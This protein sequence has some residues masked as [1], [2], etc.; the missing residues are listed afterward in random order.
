MREGDV[1]AQAIDWSDT[2][3]VVCN[4]KI[5]GMDRWRL[6]GWNPI[7]WSVYFTLRYRGTA[8]MRIPLNSQFLF[9]SFQV[10][11]E[12]SEWKGERDG[13]KSVDV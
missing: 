7:C 8:I 13:I 1:R 9:F 6:G 10:S 5:A 12:L 4:E 11:P 2:I 3:L